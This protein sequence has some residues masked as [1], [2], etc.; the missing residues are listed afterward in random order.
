[1]IQTKN[2]IRIINNYIS[3]SLINADISKPNLIFCIYSMRE[4]QPVEIGDEPMPLR[5]RAFLLGITALT[6]G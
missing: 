4:M 3:L 2:I 5:T 6:P 1:M